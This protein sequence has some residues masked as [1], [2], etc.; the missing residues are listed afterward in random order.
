MEVSGS[1]TKSSTGLAIPRWR[2]FSGIPLLLKLGSGK[3]G[4]MSG[5]EG[6]GTKTSGK[7]GK[8]NTKT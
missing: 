8:T 4:E 5:K 2:G 7:T 1:I 3:G 6:C